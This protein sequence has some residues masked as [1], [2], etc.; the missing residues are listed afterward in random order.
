MLRKFRESWSDSG[1][2]A[3]KK[4]ER[5]RAFIRFAHEGGWIDEDST[6]HLKSPK[7]TNGPTMPYTQDEIIAILAACSELPDNY[8]KVG[9]ANGRR[10][11]ALVLL[12]RYS[13][14][15]IGDIVT[16]A[17]DRLKGRPAVPIHPKDWRSG[18]R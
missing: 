6:R 15:R 17:V 4:L 1:I 9:G 3:L 13:G 11:R 18:K 16:C 8:G 10:A 7:V 2:S 5:L 14:M 12:L